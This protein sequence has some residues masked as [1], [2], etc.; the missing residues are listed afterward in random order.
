MNGYLAK[1]MTGRCASGAEADGGRRFHAVHVDQDSPWSQALCGARP[2]QR[3][4]GWSDTHGDTVTCPRCLKI[5]THRQ[6]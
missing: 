2:G 6:R 5:I 4:N 3:G 1:R